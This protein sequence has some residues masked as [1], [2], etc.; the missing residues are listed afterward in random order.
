VKYL[1]IDGQ[2]EAFNLKSSNFQNNTVERFGL[3]SVTLRYLDSGGEHSGRTFPHQCTETFGSVL[4][5][6]L[7]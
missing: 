5:I 1:I 2:S 3:A 4:F 6:N 7:S